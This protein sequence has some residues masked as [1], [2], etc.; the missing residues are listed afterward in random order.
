MLSDAY[1]LYLFGFFFFFFR[2]KFDVESLYVLLLGPQPCSVH[3]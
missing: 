1:E 2:K 3:L